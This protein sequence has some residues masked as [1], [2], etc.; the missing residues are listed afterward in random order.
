[1]KEGLN[2]WKKSLV[3]F[4]AM[5]V[6]AAC[7][8]T[9]DE[10][11]PEVPNNEDMAP[12]NELDEDNPNQNDGMDENNPNRNDQNNEE[13]PGDDNEIDDNMDLPDEDD[14]G[15]DVNDDED[16]LRDEMDNKER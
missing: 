14:E 3:A 12:D 4:V 6:M 2:M 16:D 11:E 15:L 7:G 8:T 5:F 1:M 10:P 9:N 13:M